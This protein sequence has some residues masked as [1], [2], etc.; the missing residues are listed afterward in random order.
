MN[1]QSATVDPISGKPHYATFEA[2]RGKAMQGRPS[3]R[4]NSLMHHALYAWLLLLS[5]PAFAQQQQ[6]MSDEEYLRIAFR[7][8]LDHCSTMRIYCTSNYIYCDEDEDRCRNICNTT[9]VGL[10]TIGVE[11]AIRRDQPVVAP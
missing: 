2:A 3:R 8:C 1:A 7:S 6:A 5:G 10:S 11:K 4:M 9:V